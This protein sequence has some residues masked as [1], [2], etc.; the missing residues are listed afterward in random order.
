MLD[1]A[2]L[3]PRVA[4]RPVVED[5]P[6]SLH[7]EPASGTSWGLFTWRDS[8]RYIQRVM[9][10]ALP[11]IAVDAL[12]LSSVYAVVSLVAA[13]F[14][15]E[16]PISL[17]AWLAAT[18]I[19]YLL[20]SHYPG[21]GVSA[22]FELRRIVY[23]LTTVWFVLT[24]VVWLESAAQP[25][26]LVMLSLVGLGTLVLT[27]ILRRL[28]RRWLSTTTWWRLPVVF[29]GTGEVAAQAYQ[30]MLKHPE[31]GLIPV[32]TVSD[33]VDHWRDDRMD[34]DWYLGPLNEVRPKLRERGVFW[35]IVPVASSDWQTL[36]L[37]DNIFGVVPHVIVL[38]NDWGHLGRG[39]A[40]CYDL[41]GV[42]GLRIDERLMLPLPRFSKRLMD[43]GII[44]LASP[45][46][47]L[48]FGVLGLLVRL[49]SPGPIFYSQQRLGRN[50]AKFRAW[51]FRSMVPNA[52]A[53]LADCLAKDPALKAE[54]DRDHKLK[55][56]P[57]VTK[58]GKF[59]RKTSLDELP[60]LWN[61]VRGEMS[62]VG[63]RP[64]VDAEVSR[65]GAIYNLYS[66]TLP[67]ITGL[68]QIN[69]RNNTTYAERVDFDT[70]YVRNWS[71]WMDLCILVRTIKVVLF[72]EGAY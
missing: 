20:H 22:A 9:L 15:T 36:M 19:G 25:G 37:L 72:R 2:R 14:A 24:I 53:V 12:A 71:L 38:P 69:G 21:L 17:P 66:R 7:D 55:N 13:S 18:Q 61:V 40:N 29:F 49:S 3:A 32:G 1:E 43:L 5:V 31:Q 26:H 65:Y 63:P 60:Q 35:G 34:P 8:V 23:A 50:G 51:K 44:L 67:G 28:T 6:E 62:L 56:D 48:V 33:L 27:P 46:L 52:D 39:G 41:A 70:I 16:I 58:I 47:L 4:P 64:I 68:W 30:R 11:L 54:W 59:L 57:R 42:V 45:V 10:T